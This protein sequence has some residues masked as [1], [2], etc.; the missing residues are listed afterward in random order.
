MG[1]IQVTRSSFDVRGSS[2][3]VRRSWFVVAS[4]GQYDLDALE[5]YVGAKREVAPAVEGRVTLR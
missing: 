3:S 4:L 1:S 2:F 5:K